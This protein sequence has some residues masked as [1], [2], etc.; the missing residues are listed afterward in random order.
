[1]KLI[2]DENPSPTQQLHAGITA[3]WRTQVIGT[4]ARLGIA[5]LLANGARERVEC[6]RFW[7]TWACPRQVARRAPARGPPQSAWC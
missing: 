6:E 2:P 3:Y 4:V 7:S 1:M 5:D